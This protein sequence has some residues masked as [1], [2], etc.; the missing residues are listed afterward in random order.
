MTLEPVPMPLIL[1][2]DEYARLVH[3]D[4]YRL[5]MDAK[6]RVVSL[7]RRML[8]VS[9]GL[10]TWSFVDIE[11]PEIRRWG[12]YLSSITAVT[13]TEQRSANHE[14]KASLA[15]SFDGYTW[16]GV[17]WA[18]SSVVGANGLVVHTPYTDSSRFG[19]EMRYALGVRNST[20]SAFEQA[21]VT[22]DLVF[23]F[24]S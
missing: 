21:Y 23:E 6:I 13:H 11:L 9:P 24:L 18:I 22:C 1:S 2:R 8:L 17:T 3:G 16:P 12:P 19:L 20:G 7:S 4:R 10:T 14:W 15:W 5:S